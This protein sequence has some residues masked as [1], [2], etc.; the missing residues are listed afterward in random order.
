M[1]ILY[2]KYFGINLQQR[3]P[4][5]IPPGQGSFGFRA[6]FS[7]KVEEKNEV[8]AFWRSKTLSQNQNL[9]SLENLVVNF[10]FNCLFCI[11]LFL[12]HRF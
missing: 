4:E 12:N 9:S 2:L 11:Q 3:N 10:Q 5:K 8:F 1:I 6:A 7:M